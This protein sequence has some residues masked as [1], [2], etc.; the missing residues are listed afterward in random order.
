MLSRRRFLVFLGSVGAAGVAGVTIGCGGGEADAMPEIRYGE[1]PCRHCGM[2]IDDPR[3]AAARMDHGERHFDDIGCLVE[4]LVEEPAVEGVATWVHDF[5]TE[6][7]VA[8]CDATY[9]HSTAV[10]TPMAYGVIAFARREDANAASISLPGDIIAWDALAATCVA[11]S[12][13]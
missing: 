8:G 7:W 4:N 3:F 2:I 13:S 11:G 5:N 9:V 1:E 6:A 10:K 12:A